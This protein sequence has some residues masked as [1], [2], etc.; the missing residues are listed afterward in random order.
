[1][2]IDARDELLAG[3]QLVIFPEG[4]RTLEFPLDRCMPTAGLIA[5]RARVPVQTLLIEY[6][7]P[8]L[9]KAWPLSRRPELPLRARVRLGRRF[10][11]PTDIAGFTRELEAYFRDELK[12]DPNS[13]STV[14]TSS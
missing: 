7:S 2:I 8:Y 4:S 6:S 9:G 5:G 14:A 10:P 13:R 3:S 1:M 12:N 11:P